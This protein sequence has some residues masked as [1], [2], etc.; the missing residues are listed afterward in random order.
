M[1][2]KQLKNPPLVEVILEARWELQNG[3][4]P[5]TKIDRNYALLL[6]KLHDKLSS[7]Y[8]F[9]EQLPQASIPDEISPYIVK[10][11][12]RHK[13]DE[14]PLIQLGPGVLTVNHTKKYTTFD[15]F[16]PLAVSAV[17]HLF[18]VYPQ[19]EILKIASFVLRYIDAKEFDYQKEDIL[20]FLRDK[21]G[22]P[23]SLP[24]KLFD[25]TGVKKIPRNFTWT[26]SFTCTNPR[27][28]ATLKFA[29]GLSNGKPAI[30]WEQIVKSAHDEVPEMPD[31][32]QKWIQDAHKV[33]ECWFLSLIEGELEREFNNV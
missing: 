6:G 9:H 17:K 4:V 32:F 20:S 14:W 1:G 21:M 26:S 2:P 27:G 3:P 13:K 11:R 15:E 33:T 28:L 16:C 24:D 18:N 30:V 12:F 23:V 19:P 22:V 25:N 29:T 8:P 31:G 7:Q 10:H 5:E